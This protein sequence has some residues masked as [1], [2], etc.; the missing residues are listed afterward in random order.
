[1][2]AFATDPL[3]AA[4]WSPGA[5]ADGLDGGRDGEGGEGRPAAPGPGRQRRRR[6]QQPDRERQPDPLVSP[7]SARKADGAHRQRR[8]PGS[9]SS[10][11]RRRG[12]GRPRAAGRSP[13]GGEPGREAG[14]TGVR[15]SF[16][17]RRAPAGASPRSP[18]PQ[19]VP[20][21]AGEGEDGDDRAPRGR[22][23]EHPRRRRPQP[24]SRLSTRPTAPTSTAAARRRRGRG[25]ARGAGRR[26]ALE[27]TARVFPR[28][29][30]GPSRARPHAATPAKNAW[31]QAATQ[32]APGNRTANGATARAGLAGD[33]PEG[34]R[35]PGTA[36]VP[37]RRRGRPP[38]RA[39]QPD[40]VQAGEDEQRTGWVAGGVGGPR[41]G[42]VRP[43]RVDEAG[44]KCRGR[45]P[46][47]P[48]ARYSACGHGPA[49]PPQ[50]CSARA[51]PP[52][53]PPPAAP[54]AGPTG[55]AVPGQ[56]RA[57]STPAAATTAAARGGHEGVQAA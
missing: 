49:S 42:G 2:S 43:D 14:G 56:G 52:R 34:H 47:R 19:V 37:R 30:R 32:T 13:P 33:G 29:P 28:P 15:S 36:T 41:F 24:S 46:G 57:P 48:R 20:R 53:R 40:P 51:R 6:R 11:P 12:A 31:A 55:R 21:V 5:A 44:R 16:A 39:A 1:M 27:L 4:P 50:P 25:E 38:S 3:R 18:G 54:A 35:H 7:C 9:L 17:S 45:G 10:R 22:D 8:E 23:G 26:P